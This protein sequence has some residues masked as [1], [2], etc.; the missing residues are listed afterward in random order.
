MGKAIAV[1]GLTLEI[2]SIVPTDN[3]TGII[4]ITSTPS[5]RL[6]ADNKAAYAGGID[7]S[8][9]NITCP[10]LLPTPASIP[11]PGPVTGTIQPAAI[12]TKTEGDLVNREDD[13]SE[14]LSATPQI[15]NPGGDP[16]DYPTTFK[17][18]I[19]DAGQTRSIAA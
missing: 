8:V 18:K 16:I 6:K 4:T 1:L 11:D 15:P 7:I 14:I 19:S 10:G 17:V 12:R 3:V 2:V 13:E 5:T 9:T